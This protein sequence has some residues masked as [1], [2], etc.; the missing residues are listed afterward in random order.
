[1]L[2]GEELAGAAEARLHLVHEE[3]DSVVV[4]DLLDLLEV[5]WRWRHDP[6][7][8][9]DGFRDEGGDVV[10]GIELD[11][12]FQILRT[13]EIAARKGLVVRAA[14]AVGRGVIGAT[15]EIGAATA[16]A[17]AVAGDRE[18][19]QAPAVEGTLQ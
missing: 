17:A 15:R 2:D 11:G 7:L 14:V 12:P 16:L 13:V 10:G 6:A 4:Q 3:E 19:R 18:G 1:M 8:A 5:A 9:H